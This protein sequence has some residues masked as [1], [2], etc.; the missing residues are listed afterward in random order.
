MSALLPSTKIADPFAIDH[1]YAGAVT[2]KFIDLAL[3]SPLSATMSA[4]ELGT[5]IVLGQL[6]AL[7][8][9]YDQD[10]P[11]FTE[12]EIL[13]VLAMRGVA[14]PSQMIV[15]LLDMRMLARLV[16]GRIMLPTLEAAVLA[17]P[18]SA[19]KKKSK[20]K[21]A[22]VVTDGVFRLRCSAEDN[23]E[24]S[25]TIPLKGGVVAEVSA[26]Y[27]AALQVSFPK[28]EIHAKLLRASAWCSG[29]EARQK[30]PA[31]LARFITQWMLRDAE[32]TDMRAAVI[33]ASNVRNGFG[34]GGVVSAPAAPDLLVSVGSPPI[35]DDFGLGT[36]VLGA[37][38]MKSDTPP[39][40]LSLAQRLR[41]QAEQRRHG[42]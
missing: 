26:D 14:A 33:Q 19:T 5:L 38:P 40:Q 42:R 3:G 11:S 36:V 15:A 20:A 2:T 8:A 31:G 12:S 4:C 21:P 16:G 39:A 18:Y 35:D 24:T 17:T 7:R 6:G 27:V 29:N 37:V 9:S 28:V 34:Q 23:S 32:Q 13:R 41:M 10:S 22:N 1:A 25:V 30:T